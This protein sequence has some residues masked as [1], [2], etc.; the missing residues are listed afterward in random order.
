MA[1]CGTCS[2]GLVS[3][4]VTPGMAAPLS[5]VTVPS[6]LEVLTNCAATGAGARISDANPTTSA[7][8]LERRTSDRAKA[9]IRANSSRGGRRADQRHIDVRYTNLGS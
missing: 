9:A 2:A 1:S 7:H 3:V 8:Q 4:T 5:S 6:M